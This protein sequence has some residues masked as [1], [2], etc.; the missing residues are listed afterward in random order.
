[1][2]PLA[3]PLKQQYY[4]DNTKTKY[5]MI[6]SFADGKATMYENVPLEKENKITTSVDKKN[7]EEHGK[8]ISREQIRQLYKITANPTKISNH[9]QPGEPL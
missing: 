7:K 2:E 9:T 5:M 4:S 6:A 1:M 8:K 3:S